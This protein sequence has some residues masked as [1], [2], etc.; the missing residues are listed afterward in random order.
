MKRVGIADLKNNGPDHNVSW[1]AYNGPDH[2][3][4]C[5]AYNAVYV[6]GNG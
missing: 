6:V 2:N 1:T 4:S 3:I 5:T